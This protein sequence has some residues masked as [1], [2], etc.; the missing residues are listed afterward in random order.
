VT[1]VKLLPFSFSRRSRPWWV[2]TK[3][4]W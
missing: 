3:T 2:S 1:K 4:E